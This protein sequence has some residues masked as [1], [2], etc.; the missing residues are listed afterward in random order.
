LVMPRDL[1]CNTFAAHIR[2]LRKGAVVWIAYSVFRI[3]H[4]DEEGAERLHR[5]IDQDDAAM[6]QDNSGRWTQG[7]RLFYILFADPFGI[8]RENPIFQLMIDRS[9]ARHSRTL[10]KLPRLRVA[11]GGVLA[12]G[13]LRRRGCA[14]AQ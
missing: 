8:E 1:A 10:R 4:A 7:E 3:S 11:H 13:I 12:R 9:G 14:A 2:V 5:H 6:R